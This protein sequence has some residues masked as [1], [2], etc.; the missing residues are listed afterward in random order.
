MKI[1]SQPK[2]IKGIKLWLMD[3][4]VS[5]IRGKSW[6]LEI[7]EYG[8][9]QEM[10]LSNSSGNKTFQNMTSNKILKILKFL[11]LSNIICIVSIKTDSPPVF[12]PHETLSFITEKVKELL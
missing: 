12:D 1:L 10:T 11:E 6:S 5:F 9:P 4:W 3:L 8:L 2:G 7:D